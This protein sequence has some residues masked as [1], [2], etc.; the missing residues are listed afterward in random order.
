[1]SDCCAGSKVG[2]SAQVKVNGRKVPMKSFVQEVVGRT[3]LGMLSALKGVADPRTI[4]VKI[5]VV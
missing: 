4:E 5:K 3:V 2:V 1:M